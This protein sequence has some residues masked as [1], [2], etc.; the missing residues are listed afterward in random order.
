[1]E[2]YSLHLYMS[3]CCRNENGTHIIE[4]EVDKETAWNYKKCP[5]AS[6]TRHFWSPEMTLDSPFYVKL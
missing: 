2:K 3:S 6:N 4:E 5:M 1:M